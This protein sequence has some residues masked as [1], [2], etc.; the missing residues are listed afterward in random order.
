MAPNT[1]DVGLQSEGFLSEGGRWWDERLIASRLEAR[2]R[3]AS[4][5]DQVLDKRDRFRYRYEVTV[6]LNPGVRSY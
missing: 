4:Q 2:L 3:S 5:D 1:Q 6:F